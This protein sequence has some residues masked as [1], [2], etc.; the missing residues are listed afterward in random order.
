LRR[1]AFVSDVHS[2]LEALTTVF[3][4]IGSDEEIYCL[5]DVVGY[6]ANPNE[7]IELLRGRNVHTLM[8]NHDFAAVTGDVS[9]FN[10]RA[11][12]AAL[13]TRRQLSEA[14]LSYLRG[15][16][17]EMRLQIDGVRIYITHGSP[18][19]HLSEY[20]EPRTHEGLFEHY[21]DTLG[22][23]AIGLGHTHVPFVSENKKGVVFNPGSVGQ[24][25]NGD[26]RAAFAKMALEE[27]EKPLLE[28]RAVEYD[29]L[30]AASKIR[31]VGLPEQLAA[32]LGLG[33]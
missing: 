22:V 15:L 12:M 20:V 23:T 25:R 8:G 4:E 18:D 32:R 33:R 5:G 14:S 21:L 30:T 31:D 17:V 26:R 19:D 13:W 11:A 6:G 9:E 3:R 16:P 27:G 29:Y 7:V 2:N 28:L 24:P 10:A 1:V